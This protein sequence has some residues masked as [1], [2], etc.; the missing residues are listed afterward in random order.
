MIDVDAG[1][2]MAF[3]ALTALA[4]GGLGVV[5]YGLHLVARFLERRRRARRMGAADG[6]SA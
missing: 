4:A 1:T 3:A 6:R 5:A 2:L